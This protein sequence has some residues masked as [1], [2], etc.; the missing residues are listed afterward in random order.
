MVLEPQDGTEI[1]FITV[2]MPVNLTLRLHLEE[3]PKNDLLI[4]SI[5]LP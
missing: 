5:V 2:R 1:L 3:D 4:V